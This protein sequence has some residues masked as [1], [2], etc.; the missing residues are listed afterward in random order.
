MQSNI[1]NP[2]QTRNI[3]PYHIARRLCTIIIFDTEIMYS[4]LKELQVSEG[5]TK[6]LS[7]DRKSFLQ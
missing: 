6:A 5:I 7:V 4:C 2:R 3:I 1:C